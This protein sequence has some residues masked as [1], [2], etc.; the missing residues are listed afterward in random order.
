MPLHF[1]DADALADDIIARVGRRVVLAMPLGLGK[2]NLVANALFARAVADPSLSLTIFTALTLE[3]PHYANAMQRRFLEPVIERLFGGWP[4]LDYVRALRKR[5]L[6]A[7]IEVNDFFFLAGQW[8]NVPKAQQDYISTNYTH[9]VRAVMAQGINVIGQLVAK[10][11]R[12]GETRYSVSS[13]TDLT[14]ELLRLRAEG[15]TDFLMVGEVNG[16]LPFMP[17]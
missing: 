13:N 14:V 5:T 16:E 1:T 15:K 9:A 2:A 11:E 8:L 4:E 6:P 3:R 17:G 12:G 10:Q 7:N